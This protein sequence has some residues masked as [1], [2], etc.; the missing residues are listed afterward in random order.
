MPV[1]MNDQTYYR[2]AEVCQMVGISRNTLLRW[3]KV[4]M[5][6][7]E[8]PIIVY[9]AQGRGAIVEEIPKRRRWWIS[10]IE[11]EVNNKHRLY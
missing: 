8:K 11:K 3:L 10:G 2:I 9:S 5:A 1:T 4:E 6:G 7:E